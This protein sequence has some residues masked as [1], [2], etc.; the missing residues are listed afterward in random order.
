[1]NK[2]SFEILPSLVGSHI[3]FS[4]SKKVANVTS[5]ERN[6]RLAKERISRNCEKALYAKGLGGIILLAEMYY[7]YR[8][9]MYFS[10]VRGS[11]VFHRLR[12]RVME[13][14][15]LSV[16][17]RAEKIYSLLETLRGESREILTTALGYFCGTYPSRLKDF[18]R[19]LTREEYLNI[20]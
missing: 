19:V 15:A 18:R 11:F 4:F 3:E 7:F 10:A 9:E 17:E 1:M 5:L 6:I 16:D 13:Y 8:Q 20:V 14:L 12:P 2:S